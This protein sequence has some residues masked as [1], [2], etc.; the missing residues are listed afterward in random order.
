MVPH[1]P[2][3]LDRQLRGTDVHAEVDLHGVRVDDLAA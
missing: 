2:T 1:S 3:L